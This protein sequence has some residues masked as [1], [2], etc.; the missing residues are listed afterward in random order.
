MAQ[1]GYTPIRIYYSPTTTNVPLAANLAAGELAINTADGK[2]FYK[3]SSNV[4]QVIGTKGGVG[5]SS[6]TQ[7][8]YNSSGLVV[9]SGNLTFNGTVL[10]SSFAGPLNG[11]VGAT[12]ASTGAFTTCS[13]TDLTY[14]GTLTG[15][16]G[17]AAIGSTQIYK[18]A[19]GL[20]GF[21]TATPAT[22]IHMSGS[23]T[24]NSQLRMDNTGTGSTAMPRISFT[25]TS[26]ASRSSSYTGQILFT[27]TDTT[28]TTFGSTIFTSGR[29][30]AGDLS[31]SLVYDAYTAHYFNIGGTLGSTPRVI[32]TTDGLKVGS[33]S[34]NFPVTST[35][36]V[37]GSFAAQTPVIVNAATYT[38]LVTDFSLRITTTN[39]TLTLPVAT[40]YPGRI[41]YISNITANSLIS[42]SSNVIPLGSSTPGTAILPATAGKFVMLQSDSLN[43]WVVLMAN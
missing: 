31:Q 29:N 37:V 2:L 39:C 5:S 23:T 10:T 3:D 28:S 43:Y 22:L 42:A 38:L 16:T 35:L 12:T 15:G 24:A 40:S 17:I 21:G 14:T 25:R 34:T 8:L 27:D 19:A 26:N 20:V 1:T 13:A 32:I 41:L 33:A 30:I 9:G 36:T 11:T 18:D 6:T 4:V 7:V